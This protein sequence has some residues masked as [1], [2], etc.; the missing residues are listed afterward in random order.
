MFNDIYELTTIEIHMIL[1]ILMYAL[2]AAEFPLAKIALDYYTNGFFLETVRMLAGGTLFLG[3]Y[4]FRYR[5]APSVARQDIFT[6]IQLI[7]FYMY[8]SYF[9]AAWALQYMSSLKANMFSSF[10]PFA[11]AFFSYILLR[12]KPTLKRV[13]GMALG[14]VGLIALLLTSEMVLVPFGEVAHISWPEVMMLVSIVSTE[15]GYF[16]LKRLY[17]R[18]Y[19]LVFIN[20]TAMFVGGFLSLASGFMVFEQPLFYYSSLGPVLGYALVL[21]FLINVVDNALYGILIKQ[22]SI[23]FLTL[24]SFLSPIFGVLYGTLFMGETIVPM[25]LVAFALIFFGLYLFSRDELKKQ[26]QISSPL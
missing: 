21:F 10:M 23:T 6:F 19:P 11:S 2:F 14:A 4:F 5:I 24:A 3:Y 13:A 12:E 1:I 20:G 26:E 9:S 25:H 17:D 18:G 15:Y 7:I 22:Y 16:L 8:I